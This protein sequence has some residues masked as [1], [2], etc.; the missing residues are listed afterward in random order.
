[1][2]A[3][4]NYLI[5]VQS[6]QTAQLMHWDDGVQ[7]WQVITAGLSYRFDAPYTDLAVPF[8]ELGIT[9]PANT[10]LGLLAL[11]TE[12]DN[13]L[14]WAT[15][16]ARN[17]INSA[18]AT[19]SVQAALR[20]SGSYGNP[21]RAYALRLGAL[22]CP[23]SEVF[24]EANVDLRFSALPAGAEVITY[25]DGWFSSSGDILRMSI[26]DGEKAA[27][28][29]ELTNVGQSV[30]S[31]VS[32]AITASELSLDNA[33]TLVGDF[34]WRDTLNLGDIAPGERKTATFSGTVAFNVG[35]TAEISG[36]VS[37]DASLS[38]EHSAYVGEPV[39]THSIQHRI[40]YAPPSYVGISQPR[41][42]IGLGGN[43]VKGVVH[44]ESAVPTLTLQA[45][46]PAGGLSSFDCPGASSADG[47]P[48]DGAWSCAWDVGTG[49]VNDDVF[50][51]RVRA[52]DRLGQV[53]LWS[54]WLTLTLDTQPVTLSLDSATESALGDGWLAAGETSLSGQALDN[55]LASQ[56]MACQAGGQACRRAEFGLDT[57]TLS[58]TVYVYDDA[59][60][61]PISIGAANA[62]QGGE[63][64]VRSFVV[65]DSF[66]VAS[67][68]LGLNADL[69]YR[70]TLVATLGSPSGKQVT[71]H[72][73]LGYPGQN[74]DVTWDD[75]AWNI[76][77]SEESFHNTAAPYY[78]NARRPDQNLDGLAGENAQGVWTLSLCDH[79]SLAADNGFYNRSR[80]I[81]SVDR[82][83]ANTRAW[84]RYSLPEVEGQDGVTRTVELY[85]L[86]SVG[87]RSTALSLTFSV[88][89]VPP[90]I[91][92]LTHTTT[93]RPGYPFLIAG[94]VSDGGGIRAM[95]VSGI[96]PGQGYVAGVMALEY[97]P[98]IGFG[99][100]S[101]TWSY[102]DTSQLTQPGDYS[103]WVEA[104]DDAGNRSAFG[105]L[106][107]KVLAPR[108]LDK[109]V[110]PAE[111]VDLGSLVT[112]TL[113][114]YNDHHEPIPSVTITDPLPAVIT[115]LEMVQGPAFVLSSP[116]LL[117]WP[118]FSMTAWS[119]Y[120]LRFT[121]R[122]TT[123]M[124]YFGASVANTAYFS[125]ESASGASKEASL[126]IRPAIR[127]LGLQAG[128][129]LSATNDISVTLVVTIDTPLALP[130]E[131]YWQLAV[132]GRAVISPVLAYAATVPLE[133]GGHVI[134][135]T[136]YTLGHHVLGGDAVE[137]MVVST[138]RRIYLPVILRQS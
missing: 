72:Y 99:R 5:W 138:W 11:A 33:P 82:L 73:P 80:L 92:H 56:V 29:L 3:P 53:S 19:D 65:S 122:V 110:T 48:S 37:V 16:P 43:Q 119:T 83:P 38:Y 121:A 86:D 51:L 69:A 104:V 124:A 109:F 77:F 106:A 89:T 50:A 126:G 130:G 46:S 58:Q 131:G 71:L 55:R 28:R 44:D 85:G 8:A 117:A 17:A 128:Q 96:A 118:P 125:S 30:A 62:C 127:I 88:D 4:A 115:P 26:G 18:R 14:F 101:A 36:F 41:T 25:D 52:T 75:A 31:N 74:L 102:T 100:N 116:Q 95:Q 12:E 111:D 112:Y 34:L 132:D 57:Q 59:P 35:N 120:E 60:A 39:R 103:L 134:S 64:I 68:K 20:T 24:S 61:A 6:S 67:V 1:L 97:E 107:V 23:G 47:A 84:W 66:N 22:A 91:T 45:Q 76:L 79:F 114:M 87:N 9:D 7:S 123:D 108:R 135:V 21:T 63:L 94:S 27:Y 98:S 2:P 113:I 129:V 13:M 136:L 81:L 42:L 40:D 90:V 32:V 54:R 15:A 93:L 105:P 78:E 133:L 49:A 10:V 137:V 70:N